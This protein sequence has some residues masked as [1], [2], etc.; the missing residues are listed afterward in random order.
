MSKLHGIIWTRVSSAKQAQQGDS[1][2]DQEMIGDMIAQ[3]EGVT[4]RK[5]FNEQFSG[6]KDER[7]MIDEIILYIRNSPVTIDTVIFRSIDRL[8]RN[9]IFGYEVI[10]QR[11]EKEGVKLID[12][13]G[14][15]Q[16]YINTM[17]HLG[18][19]YSW[20]KVNPGETNELFKAQQGK[21]EVNQILT[22]MIGAEVNL[23][24]EGYK[25][26]SPNDGFINE[27]IFVDGKK[28]VI[29]IPD[30]VRSYLYVKM[31]ELRAS[32]A[33]TDEEIVNQ[34]NAIGYKSRTRNRWSQDKQKILGQ[35]G[36]VPLT[37]KHYQV[38]I[39]NPI[40]C[41]VNTE[42]WLPEPIKTSYKGLVSIDLFNKANK[43]KIYIE[44]FE[45]NK[46]KIHYDYSPLHAK[47]LRNNPDYPYKFIRCPLCK[48]QFN[49]SAS[50]GKSGKKFPAY[51]CCRDHKYFR[52]NKKDFEDTI[53]AF[54]LGLKHKEGFMESLEYS[55]RKKYREKEKELGQFAVSA[56]DTIA[57]LEA[58][59]GQKIE[60]FTSTQ[61]SV[62]REGIE[63]QINELQDQIEKI[64]TERN[65][66]EVEEAD[67]NAFL[68]FAKELVEHPKEML[69]GQVDINRTKALFGLVFDEMPSYDQITNGTPQL[70]LLFRLSSEYAQE[71]LVGC[72][73]RDSNS[74]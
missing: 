74:N 7:P 49:G 57:N 42:K 6:R 73:Y 43:G 69:L 15:I 13:H 71:N 53:E 31:F 63:K 51:H 21:T 4:I 18:L 5:R 2:K 65:K 68:R 58:Q 38:I 47:R 23:V 34:I 72:A 12:S 50:K 35:S 59:K 33:Y 3:K 10:K 48:N 46:V 56:G 41:G 11:L 40:Y 8:T 70:S 67:I 55:L 25:V 26:R 39:K 1:H 61:N 19:E 36:N 62:I 44:E 60:A 66:V 28:R 32:G 52:V 22:R 14:T 30:P 64:R 45:G 29:Q 24:R 54:T 9:G 16:E 17:G 20:S 27:T 37:V